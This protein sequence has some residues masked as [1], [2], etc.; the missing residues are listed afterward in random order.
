MKRLLFLLLTITPLF[1]AFSYDVVVVGCGLSGAVIAERLASKLHKKVLIIEKRNHIGGNCY[2]TIDENGILINLYGAHLFHTKEKALW[3]YVNQFDEWVRWEH[4]V[5]GFVDKKYVPIPVNITTVNTL[6]NKNI[7]TPREMD[8]WLQ[9]VQIPYPTITN[10]E[11]MAKSRVGEFLYEK[12][13]KYYTFKQ[14]NK[15]PEEL[16]PSVLARIPVRN[17]FEERYFDDP[18]QA[19]PKFGYTHFFEKLLANENIE[20]RLN[21]D[22][23]D[24]QKTLTFDT[25]IFTGPIDTYY[26]YLGLDKLEYRSIRFDFETIRNTAFYQPN[27]VINYP[28]QA[29]PYTRIIEYKHFLHQ[30]SPHTTIAKEFPTNEGEP[31]YPVPCKKNNDLLKKYQAFAEKEKNVYFLG[32]LG[33]YQ[34]LNMDQAI[35]QALILSEE[36]AKNNGR[37]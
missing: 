34:Y 23:F 5:L 33:T 32:R 4:K 27:S 25:L 12:L 20:V 35:K 13:F 17:S 9:S 21:V 22:F 6:C 19:L 1:T 18:Y 3:E 28:D 16:D 26:D 29:T 14:W 11:Q 37:E 24:L 8:D 7:T 36:I 10:G 2:D 15:Y 30:S 31:Y